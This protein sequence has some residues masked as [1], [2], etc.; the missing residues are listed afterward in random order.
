MAL[1]P[2]RSSPHL[3][4]HSRMVEHTITTDTIRLA[5]GA[6]RVAF[7]L[8]KRG[9]E[10]LDLACT[11]LSSGAGLFELLRLERVTIAEAAATIRRLALAICK[12]SPSRPAAEKRRAAM[13]RAEQFDPKLKLSAAVKPKRTEAVVEHEGAGA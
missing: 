4:D 1:D 6:V 9:V 3:S 10:I 8:N 7:E 5:T 13:W 2:L 11:W 12:N